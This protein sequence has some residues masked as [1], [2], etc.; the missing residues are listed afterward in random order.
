MTP[1]TDWDIADAMTRYGG[2]FAQALGRLY[3]AA[4][5]SNQRRLREAFPDAWAEYR[6]I[7]QRRRELH[8]RIPDRSP[9]DG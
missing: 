1:I 3:L 5:E 2:S 7:V 8:A 9:A 6:E 4:D